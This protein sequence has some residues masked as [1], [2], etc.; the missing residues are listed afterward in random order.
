MRIA[1]FLAW[2]GYQK[3]GVTSKIL[4]QIKYWKL[5]GHHVHIFV[6]SNQKM[7]D[8]GKVFGDDS[9]Y[10]CAFSGKYNI[11]N[12]LFHKIFTV[13]EVRKKIKKFSPDIIYYR[14]GTYY[15]G[16]GSILRDYPVVCEI[17]TDIAGELSKRGKF[18]GIYYRLF[19]DLQFSKCDGFIF[20][21]EEIRDAFPLKTIANK[22]ITNGY[23]LSGIDS[24]KEYKNKDHIDLIMVASADRPWYGIEKLMWLAT[25]M[26]EC[27]FHIVGPEK[28]DCPD[29]VIMYGYLEHE[30]LVSMYKDM[31]FGL[32]IF[33]LY[34]IG[35][36]QACSLKVREY[37]AYGLPVITAN[38]DPDLQNSD[39]VLIL[40]NTQDNI[41]NSVSSIK[42]FVH[43]KI[44]TFTDISLLRKKIDIAEKE[45]ERC[46]FF[47]YIV[48][49]RNNG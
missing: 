16:L 35:M 20:M 42:R 41:Y 39:C 31:D 30:K 21:T 7:E 36:Q 22:V 43:R 12:Y 11:K 34:E 2:N 8:S 33:S 44:E 6:V 47:E 10:F 27:D 14:F 5:M 15:P 24:I 46:A 4:S 9:S 17:N 40:P 25:K 3:D 29:N 28:C 26:P 38:Y 32:G 18:L 13:A 37:I 45:S 19:R 1:Y 49:Q 23:D 48:S